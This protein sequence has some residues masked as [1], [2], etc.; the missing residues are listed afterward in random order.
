MDSIEP[1][2]YSGLM[3]FSTAYLP[4]YLADKYDV[5]AQESAERA[6]KRCRT[7]AVDVLQND[8]NGYTT[9]RPG[10]SEVYLTRGKVHYV[11]LP[12]WTLRT[13]WKDKEYRF[14]MNGQTGKL[15]G[16]LP[17][18]RAKFWGLFGVIAAALSFFVSYSGIGLFLAE[19][20]FG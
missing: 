13:K 11:L 3:P 15:V 2:D 10:S 20:L 9:V 7:S 5:T 12:V 4:G 1:F 18:S 16:D 6:D 8:V 19:C 17:V 14:M